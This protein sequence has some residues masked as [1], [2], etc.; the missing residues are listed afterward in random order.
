M[1]IQGVKLTGTPINDG[2]V[3]SGLQL[4]LDQRNPRSYPRSGTTWYDLS[5]NSRN[6]TLFN[7]PTFSSSNSGSLGFSSSSLQYGTIPDIGTLQNWTAE[8]WVKFTSNLIK[9][10]RAN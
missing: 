7:V 10:V 2:L 9:E 6:A 4:Y 8:V 3:T 5:G 1:I